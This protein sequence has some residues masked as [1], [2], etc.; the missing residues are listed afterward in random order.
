MLERE[1]YDERQAYHDL[2][3]FLVVAA[4]FGAFIVLSVLA[5]IFI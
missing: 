4:A 1:V 3:A 5:A 2:L